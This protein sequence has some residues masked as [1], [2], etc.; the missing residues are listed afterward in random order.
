MHL[1]FRFE[2]VRGIVYA[3]S[4]HSV[5]INSP[6]TLNTNYRCH[7]GIL[8]CASGVLDLLL[9]AF[10]HAADKLPRDMRLC[11][12]P[13]PEYFADVGVGAAAETGAG[14]GA[15]AF[16]R[17]LLL[18]NPRIVVLCRDEQWDGESLSSEL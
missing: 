8:K 17:R 11:G 16:M 9:S 15:G 10:P 5:K 3:L 2:E 18:H 7:A 6:V 4:L 13:R 12:G 14:A 1:N